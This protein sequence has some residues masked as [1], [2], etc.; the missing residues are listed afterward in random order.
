MVGGKR[1]RLEGSVVEDGEDGLYV[2]W[3]HGWS[4]R[5][6]VAAVGRWLRAAGRSWALPRTH[7]RGEFAALVAE[8]EAHRD[9]EAVIAVA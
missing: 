6:E 1:P 7:E 5:R 2:P 8:I 4:D 9:Y 3:G